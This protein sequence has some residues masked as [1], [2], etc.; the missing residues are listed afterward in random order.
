M[1]QITEGVLFDL[2]GTLA[3]TAPDLAHALN[4]T[5]LANQKAA[6]PFEKIRP[7]VSHGGIAMIRLA[8]NIGPGD[9]DYERIREQF[10]QTYLE[11]IAKHTRLFE[12]MEKLL[13]ELEM[14]NILWGVVTNKPGWLT[15]P[16]M[17]ALNLTQRAA[18]IVSGDTIAKNKPHP[19]PLFY[20]CEQANIN[21]THCIY[22]G[23]ADRDI[24]AG[25]A[26]GMKTIGAL[27][28]YILENEDPMD[29]N[30]DYYVE[31]PEEIL[32]YI[33]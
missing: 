22:V 20:A 25:R 1:S 18:A 2:D 17:D 7:V 16:L 24:A 32:Q 29:W 11:N 26:A 3:D 8:F 10:L 31:H 28:G 4:E 6:L 15:D 27:F 13:H 19:E 12:G 23:D 9:D 5:L 30:A 14:R 33:S 21:P